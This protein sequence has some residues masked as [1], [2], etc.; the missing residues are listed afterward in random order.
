MTSNKR[1]R[2][3]D[4]S[5]DDDEPIFSQSSEE[6][7]PKR[8]Q[9]ETSAKVPPKKKRKIEEDNSAEKFKVRGKRSV[10]YDDDNDFRMEDDLSDGDDYAEMVD[11]VVKKE[12]KKS[13]DAKKKKAATKKEKKTTKKSA[14]A[15]PKKEKK[16]KKEKKPDIPR[17]EWWNLPEDQL[18]KILKRGRNDD[19][20]DT[21]KHNGPMM[22]PAYEPHGVKPIY[23]GTSVD[24]NPEEEEVLSMYAVMKGS[25]HYNNERF[26]SNFWKSFLGVLR[27]GHALR[28]AKLADLNLEPIYRWYIDKKAREKALPSAD[29]KRIKEEKAAEEESHKFC[30]IDGRQE[31]VGNF[32]VEPPQLFRGRGEHP[33]TGTLK[34]RIQ[35]EDITINIGSKKDAP[36]PPPGHKWKE[37]VV[38]KKVQWLAMWKDFNGNVKYVQLSRKASFKGMSDYLKYEKARALKGK[39]IEKIRKEYKKDWKS[40]DVALRQRGTVMYFID[41]LALRVG[42]DK[43]TSKKADTVGCCSLKVKHLSFK[44]DCIIELDFLGKDSIRYKNDVEVPQAVIKNLKEFVKGKKKSEKIFDKLSSTELN[45]FL[46]DKMPGLTAKVFR[47]YN[48]SFTLDRELKKDETSIEGKNI[49]EKVQYFNDANRTV[50]ILCNHQKAAAKNFEEQIQK[51]DH[52]LTENKEYLRRLKKALKEWDEKDRLQ[53]DWDKALDKVNKKYE[54]EVEEYEKLLKKYDAAAKTKKVSRAVYLST[55]GIAEPKKPPKPKQRKLPSTKEQLKKRI[56]K[57]KDVV[58]KKHIAR[59]EKENNKTISLGT[60][61]TNYCDPRITVAFC[62][63]QTVPVKKILSQTLVD[64]F[65]WAL[66]A[67][68][69]FEF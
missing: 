46:K 16:E 58:A 49:E 48:A 34:P 44:G 13:D 52:D 42:N 40:N 35:P 3:E 29:K 56:E 54:K 68:E 69:D 14:S 19:K 31:L 61:K 21:L 7:I 27:K 23:K 8:K 24:L 18:E 10:V 41:I 22:A 11:L 64:S 5:S 65:P 60:S 55:E 9:R 63:R 1:K 39:L 32:R 45:N 36:K 25:D 67:A 53:K 17:F 59:Q 57:Q 28:K 4:A 37:V 6:E 2:L 51:V 30:E 26:Q 43:D 38:N 33:L 20:W 12:K 50:A 15:T 47:T 62:K 66:D